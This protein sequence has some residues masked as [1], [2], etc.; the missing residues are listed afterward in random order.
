[1]AHDRDDWR[2]EF[3]GFRVILDFRNLR[4]VN[5]WRQLFAGHAEFRRDE[6]G[7]IKVD[8]LIDGRHDAHHEEFLDN[9]G[10]RVAHL[11]REVLDGNRLRQFDVFRM[12][13]LDLRRLLAALVVAA[14][15]AAVIAIAAKAV[16]VAV[17]V[18]ALVAA[19][20]AVIA[21]IAA[22]A[23]VAAAIRIV[24]AAIAVIAVGRTAVVIVVVRGCRAVPTIIIVVIAVLV[25]VGIAAVCLIAMVGVILLVVHLRLLHLSVCFLRLFR[26]GSRLILR[27]RSLRC[28]L[29]GLRLF[30]L[31]LRQGMFDGR[32]LFFADAGEIIRSLEFIALEDIENYFAIRV[33]LFGELKNSVFGHE[34]TPG[35][36]F[37]LMAPSSAHAVFSQSPHP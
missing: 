18:I 33:E 23:M 21:V 35:Y 32:A 12:C 31:A 1:M 27:G 11:G 29:C 37:I 13:N 19:I 8:F 20:A 9:F 14:L 26:L 7:R 4:R 3:Q 2:T 24:I 6:S 17:A 36:Y 28:G 15:A 10:C 25:T 16:V 30:A 22:V 34:S 5:L